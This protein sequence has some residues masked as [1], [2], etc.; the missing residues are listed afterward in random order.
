MGFFGAIPHYLIS[1]VPTLRPPFDPLPNPIA[2]LRQLSTLQWLQFSCAF[3]AWTWDS[4]DFFSVSLT[5]TQLGK[6]F[7][8]STTD[9]TWGITLVLMLRSV[10]A[11]IFGIASDRYGRKW[12]FVVN[13]LLFVAFELGTG[14]CKTY[15]QFLAVRAL[16][17][18]AM[19]GLCKSCC[20]FPLLPSLPLNLAEEIFFRLIGF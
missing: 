4:F 3:A 17:G 12:P 5:T 8:K 1:R 16:F 19:G 11:V 6:D 7:G 20:K 14:F 13:N 15:K 2:V 10:G 18:I 9:I